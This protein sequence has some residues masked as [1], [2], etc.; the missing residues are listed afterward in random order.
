[1]RPP[2]KIIEKRK[3]HEKAERPL[4]SL[5]LSDRGYAASTISSIF[6]GTPTNTLFI[7][8]RNVDINVLLFIA[9][10]YAANVN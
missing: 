8:T 7:E 10:S 1:M 3:N 4:N 6:R 9:Y 5:L 2:E